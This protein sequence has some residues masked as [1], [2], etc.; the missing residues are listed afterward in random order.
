MRTFSRRGRNTKGRQEEVRLQICQKHVEQM[1]MGK[2]AEVRPF[3]QRVGVTLLKGVR[4][5]LHTSDVNLPIEEQ[6]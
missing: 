1:A 2:V 3:L 5:F 6:A 4:I